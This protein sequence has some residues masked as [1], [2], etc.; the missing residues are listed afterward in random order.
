MAYEGNGGGDDEKARF[1]PYR[2]KMLHY[3]GD[4]AR[5]IFIVGA[6]VLIVAQSTGAN[7]PISTF[8]S[9]VGAIV[10]VIAAG[11][12]NP[13][14]FG[15]HWFNAFLSIVGV[16][17]FGTSAVAHYRAGMSV[18]DPSFTYTEAISLLSLFALYFTTR[19]IRG[20]SQ[21]KELT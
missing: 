14:Q 13:G 21:R 6:I 4:E 15:I 3:H 17:V 12:T 1:A 20:L 16:L 9:V 18:F 7:L 11:I 5:V 19:T 10:L 2:R 8:G